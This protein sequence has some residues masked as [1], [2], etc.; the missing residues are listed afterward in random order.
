MGV[1]LAAGSEKQLMWLGW[2]LFSQVEAKIAGVA[3]RALFSQVEAKI[4]DVAGVG[5]VLAGGSENS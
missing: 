2:T 3:R 4:S 5:I 1:V